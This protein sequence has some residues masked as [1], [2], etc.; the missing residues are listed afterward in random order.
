MKICLHLS[1]F[2]AHGIT[3]WRRATCFVFFCVSDGHIDVIITTRHSG[4]LASERARDDVIADQAGRQAGR[5]QAV[6]PL[7]WQRAG[8]GDR[9]PVRL[10]DAVPAERPRP[11]H[12]CRCDVIKPA[13]SQIRARDFWRYINL[14][15][16]VY[17]CT[18]FHHGYRDANHL[19]SLATFSVAGPM[20]WN[21]LPDFIRDPTSSTD[22]FRRLFKTY[23]FAR[24]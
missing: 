13:A 16:C 22:C 11:R 9:Q 18:R 24:Y 6:S 3:R 17:V 15:V 1:G 10:P 19:T 12:K 21:S 4:E 20:A 14:Y 2:V 8:R 5:S 23:M 7:P